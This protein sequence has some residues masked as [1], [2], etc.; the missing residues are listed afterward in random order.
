MSHFQDGKVAVKM[1]FMPISIG[2]IFM[3]HFQDGIHAIS[4]VNIFYV[5]FSRWNSCDQDGI[6]AI[7]HRQHLKCLISK[8]EKLLSR[9]N[10]FHFP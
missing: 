9:W 7:F 1:E 4:I 2:S 10:S 6:H 8:M 5:S 3:S